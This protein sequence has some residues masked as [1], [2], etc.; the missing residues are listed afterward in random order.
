[1]ARQRLAKEERTRAIIEAAIGLFARR[2]FT[3]VTSREI[4]SA[5]GV[6]EALVFKHFPHLR[7][8]Y[9]AI[10]AHRLRDP[11]PI[12]A[13]DVDARSL[14]DEECLTGIARV[15]LQRVEE[16]DTFLRLLLRSALDGHALARDFRRALIDRVRAHIER[17]MRQR[18]MRGGRGGID[19]EL[20]SRIFTGMIMAVLLQRHIFREPRA[21]RIPSA[22]LAGDLARLFLHGVAGR[23][24]R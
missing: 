10:L 2:G 14:S 4:A 12:A 20:A 21:R 17:R 19:P 3:G 9:E 23:G 7:S 11:D 5:A 1:M 22:R 24:A 16:D 6:S 8:L 15:I 13:L 18:F